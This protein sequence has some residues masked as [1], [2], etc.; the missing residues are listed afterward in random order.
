[1][2]LC[3]LSIPLVISI[4]WATNLK[5]MFGIQWSEKNNRPV[6]PPICNTRS[7]LQ[8]RN[9]KALCL[10]AHLRPSIALVVI[11]K[12]SNFS[13]WTVIHNSLLQDVQK[14]GRFYRIR[15]NLLK[16]MEMR[17][18]T[19]AP[20]IIMLGATHIIGIVDIDW[21]RLIH[22]FTLD[23][24]YICAANYRRMCKYVNG[25][26]LLHGSRVHLF[27]EC[28][29]AEETN[30]ATFRKALV[31]IIFDINDDKIIAKGVTMDICSAITRVCQ[32][33]S[34]MQVTIVAS[35]CK[36]S[37][38][39]GCSNVPFVEDNYR[40]YSSASKGFQPCICIK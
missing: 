38:R 36:V 6:V 13:W 5:A 20:H 9:K 31:P 33:S 1:M 39:A 26:A 7:R 32:Y 3:Q 30:Y 25:N 4:F 23:S 24:H 21:Q 34:W 29:A 40:Y 22:L 27:V 10:Y 12:N 8:K 14:E 11:V 37:G 35:C 2:L 19:P 18:R 16:P 15:Q 17:V 28:I